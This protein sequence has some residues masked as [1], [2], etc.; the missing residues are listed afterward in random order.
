[1][2]SKWTIASILGIALLLSLAVGLSQ[3]QGPQPPEEGMQPQ[4]AASVAAA[5]GSRIPIQGRLTDASGNPVPDGNYSITASIYDV[6]SEGSALCYKNQ[7]VSVSNGLFNMTIDN[8]TS[9][10]IDGRQLYLG[11]KVGSDAEM[12]PRQPIYPV[13]YAWSLMPGAKVS[14]N[15]IGGLSGTVV[16]IEGNLGGD[17]MVWRLGY[18]VPLIPLGRAN[19][20]VSAEASGG[21]RAY[22]VSGYA[23]TGA[24]NGIAYGVYGGADA[25]GSGSAAYGV[26]GYSENGVAIKA[27]GTGIIQST[28]RSYLWIS[29][30]ALQKA[31]SNDAT[32]LAYDIYGGYKVYGGS[33]WTTNKTVLLPIT[34]PGQLYGQNI[35]VT[36]LDIYC[37]A[38]DEFT[39]LAL[40]R[41]RRQNGVNNGDLILSDAT[42][43]C[44]SLTPEVEHWDL[45]QNNVLSDQQGVL[46]LALQVIWGSENSYVQIGGVRLTLEH[47]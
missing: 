46:Y 5:V 13:P 44:N 11:I 24:D 37:L 25:T 41:M 20:G 30:N 23:E 29:G 34:I 42:Y 38:S 12:N 19:T 31:D 10:G 22:G 39:S 17:D 4:A 9:D 3:A 1:M 32:R 21:N 45:T 33:T 7:S 28:A 18:S 36:G 27:S 35:T 16:D 2:T 47:D 8:C 14:Y 43:R 26:Y 40:V 6:P 15:P